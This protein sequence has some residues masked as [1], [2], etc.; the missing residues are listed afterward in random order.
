MD[1]NARARRLVHDKGAQ[2][3]ECPAMECCALRRA[4]RDPRAND[5]EIFKRYRPLRAFSRRNNPFTEV[6]VHPCGK[7]PLLAG[8]LPQAA[9][10]ALATFALQLV[11]EAAMLV[12]NMLKRLA[13]VQR[14]VT[15]GGNVRYAQINT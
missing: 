14:A 11:S 2:L 12:A 6:V 15:I 8:E 4:S 7:A 1:W 5:L 10:G 9:A 3:K 13:L